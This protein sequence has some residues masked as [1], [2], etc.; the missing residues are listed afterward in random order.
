MWLD[1]DRDGAQSLPAEPG[2]AAVAVELYRVELAGGGGAG[3][4]TSAAAPAVAGTLV[5]R[6]TTSASGEFAFSSVA[7]GSY[8][9]RVLYPES[10]AVTWDSEGAAD[11]SALVLVPERGEAQ[12]QV[13]LAGDARADL[14]VTTPAGT[15]VDGTVLLW[16]AGPDGVFGTDDDLQVPVTAVGG[17]VL[18]DGLPPGEYRVLSQDGAVVSGT[19][20]LSAAGGAAAVTLGAAP[21][22]GPSLA[23]TGAVLGTTL[24][25]ASY[26]VVGGLVLTVVA[27]RR[28][29]RA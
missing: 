24:L 22:A 28:G 7:P 27:R 2:L 10:L 20:A 4:V 26:L 12:A 18:A 25:A 29:R 1:R 21:A 17:R 6:V 5:A 16:W 13:G 14:R 23:E 11:A 8:S 19:V 3:R 9:V 15:P